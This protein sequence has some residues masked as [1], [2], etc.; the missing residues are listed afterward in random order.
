MNDGRKTPD[1]AI[2]DT[3]PRVLAIIAERDKL[4]AEN[5]ELRKQTERLETILITQF[6]WC[7]D[8]DCDLGDCEYA[9]SFPVN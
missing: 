2:R 3:D 6:D 1:P 9:H 5:D 7:P 4:R 8:H